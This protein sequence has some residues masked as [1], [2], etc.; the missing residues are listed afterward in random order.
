MERMA[1]DF[2]DRERVHAERNAEHTAKLKEAVAKMKAEMARMDAGNAPMNGRY[3]YE[4][5]KVGVKTFW[6]IR[7]PHGYYRDNYSTEDQVQAEAAFW[8]GEWDLASQARKR[9]LIELGVMQAE[10]VS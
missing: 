5:Y 8:N 3:T 7:G 6:R 4:S 9:R 1:T 10:V 2:H